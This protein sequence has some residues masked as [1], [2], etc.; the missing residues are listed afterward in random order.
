MLSQLCTPFPG[1]TQSQAAVIPTTVEPTSGL[2][3]ERFAGCTDLAVSVAQSH[4]GPPCAGMS[5]P[6]R[7]GVPQRE[8][9]ADN[10][11]SYRLAP[12]RRL[13]SPRARQRGCWFE[14]GLIRLVPSPA[15]GDKFGPV[16]TGRI[17]CGP[18]RMG[19]AQSCGA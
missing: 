6:L 1:Y 9:R 15:A 3:R 16:R 11:H 14:D 12:A 8:R 10:T 2:V 4:R 13:P 17:K 19:G 18:C 7:L 5:F